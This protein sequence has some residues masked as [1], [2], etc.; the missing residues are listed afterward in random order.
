MWVLD[1]QPKIVS[2]QKGPA[3]PK[4]AEDKKVVG[5][6]T[7]RRRER[8]LVEG[9]GALSPHR[10][11]DAV[12]YAC[13]CGLGRFKDGWSYRG[14]QGGDPEEATFRPRGDVQVVEP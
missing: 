7:H 1:G 2:L 13:K 8:P 10:L 14:T 4:G 9:E 11:G 3:A 6:L 12:P 5:D